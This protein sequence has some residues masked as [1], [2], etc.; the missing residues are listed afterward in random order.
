M[1]RARALNTVTEPVVRA[2][3][4]TWLYARRGLG[5][6]LAALS[7]LPVYRLLA[8]DTTGLAGAVTVQMAD[9]LRDFGFSV[10]LLALAVALVLARFWWALQ[11]R[12][13][14]IADKLTRLPTRAFALSCAVFAGAAAFAFSQFALH[15]DPNLIDATSQLMQARYLASGSFSGPSSALGAFW[16]LQQSI[17]T[18]AGWVSQYPPGHV[19][20]LALGYLLG[21]VS[22]VGP[23]I[24]A[25]TVYFG[26][27]TAELLFEENRLAARASVCCSQPRLSCSRTRAR[28]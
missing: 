4:D 9:A 22:L 19:A 16:H 14:G 26:V 8:A 1:S 7:I 21:A 10:L 25:L 24:L 23:A 3:V 2:R 18:P 17:T 15:G 6:V 20:L 28:T 12:L 11:P 5:M 13:Y 27:R